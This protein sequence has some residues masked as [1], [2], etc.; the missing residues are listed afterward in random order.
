MAPTGA[1]ARAAWL[2]RVPAALI[3]AL[4]LYVAVRLP[5]ELL[6]IGSVGMLPA[7]PGATGMPP[8][9]AP[10]VLHAFLR[11]DSGWYVRIIRDGYAY[12]DCTAPGVP[13]P[14]ASIAF[15]PV[16]PYS[17]RAVMKLGASLPLAS[18]LVT[19]LAL[20]LAIWGVLELSKQLGAVEGASKRAAVAMLAFPSG[21]FLSAGYAEVIFLA[22]A[23]WGLVFLE[24]G[25][26]MLAAVLFAIGALTRSQ[27]MLLV[28]A[29]AGGTL[30][31]RDWRAFLAV[32]G[33]SGA[34]IGAY[35]AWQHVTYGD[36]L[37]FMHARRGW[38]FLGQPP[39]DLLR[40]YWARTVSGQLHLEGWLDFASIPFLAVM[41]VA[42]WRRLGP[43]YGAYCALLL[44]VPMA[45][46]Q[47]WALSRI[48]LCA[49]PAFL[50]LG[51][52]AKQRLVAIGL[53]AFGL[54]W[55]A[56]AGLRLANG[57]FVGT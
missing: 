9:E 56:M 16:Y 24:R 14:Q 29:V 3:V 10:R 22:L 53:M 57:M 17:V 45:S 54:V 49:F 20:I 38:G 52:W 47:A 31:K 23:L 48:A 46:G 6:T 27:G 12:A 55:L 34:L 5:V 7:G 21:I 1:S 37:A 4:G 40:E 43:T 36:A 8:L 41:S 32:S 51:L 30:L 39:L 25:R 35:L 26:F 18:F 2:T 13:C 33:V 19:H 42:A 28:A 15:L 50:V 11:W 44:L